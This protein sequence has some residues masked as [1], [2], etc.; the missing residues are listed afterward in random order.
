MALRP[1]LMF[2]EYG[3]SPFLD[4]YRKRAAAAK[5]TTQ[6]LRGGVSV[7]SGSGGNI[8][9]LAGKDGVVVIDS[10]VATS[11]P[12]L[13]QALAALSSA[14]VTHLI[15]THWHFDHTD[16]NEWMHAQGASIL[17]HENT[18]I[19]LSTPQ[20]MEAIETHFP[21]AAKGA[22]PV[23]TFADKMTLRANGEEMRLEHVAPAHTDTDLLV[24]FVHA[25]VIHAGDIWFNNVYPLIDVSSGGR[26]D[27]MIAGAS[28]VLQLA[29]KQTIIIAGHGPVGDATALT[30]YRDML[31]A[32]RD[33][34]V[35]LKQK[36]MTL[37]EAVAAKPT[38]PFDAVWGKNPSV[39]PDVFARLVYR[40]L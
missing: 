24:H 21:A 10:G 19:R 40:T 8:G 11:Q 25:D 20:Y 28:R 17:A 36:G 38:A 39:G 5:I 30:A 35:E 1:R 2:A 3:Q 33:R 6:T 31:A 27:G 7:L 14:K 34:V 22:W 37:E 12:Q 23:K 9:V 13:T 26:I 16:G 18:R 29:G 32:V 15:N 4:A